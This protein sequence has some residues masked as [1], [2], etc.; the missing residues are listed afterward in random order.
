[1]KKKLVLFIGGL[2]FGGMERVAF[3][4]KELLAKEYDVTIVTLYQQSA[5]YEIKEEYYNLNVPPSNKKIVTFIKRFI[6]TAKMKKE[7]KPDIVFSFGMYS[8]YLNILSN[9]IVMKK[10]TTI[11][12]IRSYDWLTEPFF[13]AKIDK[14]IMKHADKVNSV[15]KLIAKDAEKIWQI[16]RNQ[17]IVIYNPYNIQ[18]IEQKSL[19]VVD[20]F[21]F[22]NDKYYVITMG[23][24]ANQ[25]GYNHLIRA[26][27]KVVEK[28]NDMQ[29][30]ILGNGD[31]KKE[32]EMMIE[33]YK[34]QEHIKLLEGKKNPYKYVKKANLYVLS[35]LSEGFPNALCEAMCIGTPVVS[36]NCKSGPSEILFENDEEFIY[37][38]KNFYIGD[39]GILSK[40]LVSDRQYTKKEISVSEKSLAEAICFA[41]ENKQQMIEVS[42]KAKEH[43]NKFNYDKFYED[44]LRILK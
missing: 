3:I 34:M 1:M 30:L 10:P 29:L 41:Y 33:S 38:D 40:E 23:R 6:K 13:A 2:N 36:V 35:S 32:L 8:N 15:S 4:A 22:E 27:S 20:D 24:L 9:Y 26:F 14:W 31:K 5:D 18:T 44:F 43:M 42:R 37:E 12:G 11:V 7:L 39:Y 17:N 21:E 28:H 19:E 25:K 16:P